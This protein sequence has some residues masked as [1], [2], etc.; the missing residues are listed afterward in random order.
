M[1]RTE[2]TSRKPTDLFYDVLREAIEAYLVDLFKDTSLCTIHTKR[3]T[4]T[5]KDIQLARLIQSERP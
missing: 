4:I 3:V 1:A 5:P 2:Q